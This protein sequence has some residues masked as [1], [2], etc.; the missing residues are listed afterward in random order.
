ME[1][2]GDKVTVSYTNKAKEGYSPHCSFSV[3]NDYG[4]EIESFADVWIF[5]TIKTGEIRTENHEFHV[6]RLDELLKYTP[7]ALPSDWRVPVYLVVNQE[8]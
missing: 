6:R 2:G 7:V 8:D 4:M 5:D 3:Y 1:F